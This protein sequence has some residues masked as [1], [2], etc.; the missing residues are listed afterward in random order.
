MIITKRIEAYSLLDFI[1]GVQEGVLEGYHV[2][3]ENTSFPQQFGTFYTCGLH[4]SIKDEDPVQESLSKASNQAYKPTSELG[5]TQG[6]LE[7]EN[8]SKAVTEDSKT[9]GKTKG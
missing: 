6:T 8:A 7:T 1:K 9:K 2:S 4:K 3:D 5:S